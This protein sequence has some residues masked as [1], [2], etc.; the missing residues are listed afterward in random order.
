VSIVT[1]RPSVDSVFAPVRS[2]TAFE[3]TLER[4]GTAIKL[5]LLEPGARL[6]AERELCLQL[7]ISRSTLRQALTALVQ[8][9]HLHA[10]RATSGSRSSS[11]SRC[12]P[13]SG[14]RSNRSRR[15]TSWWRP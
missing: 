12:W 5:G 1:P 15:W 6:P 8:S 10:T 13:R 7:G 9:G 3:E 11:P 4:L 2:Q 14:R